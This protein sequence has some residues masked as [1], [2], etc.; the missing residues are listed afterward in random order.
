MELLRKLIDAYGISAS[1]EKVRAIIA[2]E[3]KP[4]VDE[5]KSD[6]LGNLIARKKGHEPRVMLAAHMDEIGL[7][8]RSIDSEGRIYF[9]SIG[10]IV[11]LTI[12]GQRVF[13]EGKKRIEGVITTKEISDNIAIKEL[14]KMENMYIDTGLGKKELEKCIETGDYISLIQESAFLGSEDIFCGK[15]LDDRIGCYILIELAKRL[16]KARCEI[17]YV[18]TVQEEIGLY[19]AKTSAYTVNPSW[20]IAVD[21]TNADTLEGTKKLGKGP[22]ITIR[23]A[24]MLG[25]K[26]IN[27][28]LKGIAKKEKIPLQKDVSDAG[29]TDALTIALSRGGIP[30]TVVSVAVKNIHSTVGIAHRKDIENAITL[31]EKLLQKPPKVCLV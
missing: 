12:I 9:S 25:N 15:A 26:C 2:K 16:K 14:P 24:A 4:Y 6:N 19:G 10:G 30:A 23:D 20:A 29:S 7:V 31:L 21:T 22:C 17:Y 8:I 18:F 5:I 27:N 13:I 11:P 28:W 1:E 3:I